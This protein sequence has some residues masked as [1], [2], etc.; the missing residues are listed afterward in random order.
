MIHFV[1]RYF[2]EKKERT[3]LPKTT[4]TKGYGK[5]KHENCNRVTDGTDNNLDASDTP[6]NSG[7]Y[8]AVLDYRGFRSF[9]RRTAMYARVS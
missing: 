9:I 2:E 7:L 6:V 3:Q 1:F 4:Q 5:A 8:G